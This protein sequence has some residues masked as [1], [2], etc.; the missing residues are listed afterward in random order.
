M[1]DK[2]RLETGEKMDREHSS[3]SGNQLVKESK[4]AAGKVLPSGGTDDDGRRR[5]DNRRR[6]NGE[7]SGRQ[8]LQGDRSGSNPPRKTENAG[9]N[10]SSDGEDS[11]GERDRSSRDRHH[12]RHRKQNC[13]RKSRTGDARD[14]QPQGHNGVGDG[15]PSDSG[16]SDD[17]DSGRGR[18]NRR[19]RHNSRR[20]SQRKRQ[21]AS[22]SGSEEEDSSRRENKH[23]RWLKPEKFD[24][25]GSFET[26][27]YMFENCAAYNDG[28]KVTKLHIYV[29]HLPEWLR[30][31][32]GTR[33]I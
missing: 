32:F 2:N 11:D 21:G 24:G 15:P 17:E 4:F 6:D 22:R 30:N 9:G 13:R 23:K 8:E 18:E 10:P 3:R 25:R 26:F 14:N 20:R 27:L 33:P 12:R 7:P 1:A 28:M 16:D 5:G 31:F 19:S 29:G